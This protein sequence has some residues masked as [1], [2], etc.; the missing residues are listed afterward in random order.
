MDNKSGVK[1]PFYKKWWFI[2]IVV[3]VGLGIIGS[4]I[5]QGDD[6]EINTEETTTATEQTTGIAES[7]S[8][9]EEKANFEDMTEEEILE[10][11][12]VDIADENGMEYMESSIST[13]IVKIKVGTMWDEDHL[14]SKSAVCTVD[15]I[16][17]IFEHTNADRI[18]VFFYVTMIDAKGNESEDTAVSY[19][20]LKEEAADINYENFRDMVLDYNKLIAISEETYIHP[21]IKKNLED[22]T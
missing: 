2:V 14:M 17:Q 7:K 21:G 22:L 19:L 6:G 4:L 3:L 1:K 13:S 15:L 20:I 10:A 8:T 9:T 5:N 12:S 16:E 18:K 11:I